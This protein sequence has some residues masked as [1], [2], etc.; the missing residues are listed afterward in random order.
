MAKIPGISG[1]ASKAGEIFGRAASG[2]MGKAAKDVSKAF[3]KTRTGGPQYTDAQLAAMAKKEQ[4]RVAK[5][6]KERADRIAA[7]NR[8]LEKLKKQRENQ[9]AKEKFIARERR[10]AERAAAA[11]KSKA[12]AA[13]QA[14]K[15]AAKAKRRK[16]TM[17][18][19]AVSNRVRKPKTKEPKVTPKTKEPKVTQVSTAP[20]RTPSVT[21]Q[22]TPRFVST[23]TGG[24]TDTARMLTKDVVPNR[25]TLPAPTG[26]TITERLLRQ[27]AE[28]LFEAGKIS[29]A[30]LD[31]RLADIRPQAPKLNLPVKYEPPVTNVPKATTSVTEQA[32]E[33]AVKQSRGGLR[34][35]VKKIPARKIGGITAGAGTAAGV[36]DI[37]ME[38]QATPEWLNNTLDALQLAGAGVFGKRFLTDKGIRNKILNLLGIG[39]TLPG[40]MSMFRPAPAPVQPPAAPVAPTEQSIPSDILPPG[41]DGGLGTDEGGAGPSGSG[42]VQDMIDDAISKI[43]SGIGT[44]DD[45]ATV[46]EGEKQQLDSAVNQALNELIAS[47]GGEEAVQQGLD[48]GDPILMQQLA[49]IEAD[50]QAGMQAIQ[51]NFAAAIAQI[52]GY[53]AEASQLMADTARALGQDFETGALGLENAQVPMGLTPEEAM[54]AGVSDTALGGAGVTGAAL[55]RG[56][57]GAAQAQALADALSLG[58]TLSGQKATAALSQADLEA[59]LS[60]EMLA[61]KGEA[62]TASAQRQYEERQRKA[63]ID[64]ENKIRAAELKYQRAL[65]IEDRK[66]RK[67]ENELDRRQRIAEIKLQKELE[68][69]M[70]VANM[71]PSERAAYL[72]SQSAKKAS[73]PKWFGQRDSRDANTTVDIKTPDKLPVTVQDVNAA[74]DQIDA[75]MMIPEAT[76][77]ATA[78]AVWVDFYNST[79]QEFPNYL[80]IYK[81]LGI[82]TTASAMVSQLFPKK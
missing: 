25:I 80:A 40:G 50:Y 5:E 75:T 56:F 81:A 10:A 17:E 58:T 36:A 49:M 71:S 41:F 15:E 69:A 23:A 43:E 29:R 4:R 61:A 54:A 6:A 60:R 48:A 8:E 27:E 11:S 68:L 19:I 18:K 9:A 67:Q 16:E 82:P 13:E 7:E 70:T 14:A 57:A 28:D 55:T 63:E 26:E 35:A 59:A 12:D 78:F 44:P 51:N 22:V 46:A 72:G 1:A 76:N 42:V 3:G 77:A 66:I 33:E 73:V 30:Q 64:R 53:Q 34:E 2:L 32:L 62:R 52:S 24:V 21:T 45:A 31:Q 47:Y 38:D 74:R 39:G 79:K 20:T 65:D 37:L